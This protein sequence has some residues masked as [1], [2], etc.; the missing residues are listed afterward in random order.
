MSEQKKGIS[1]AS[2]NY[3]NSNQSY[4]NLP[5]PREWRESKGLRYEEDPNVE[6]NNQTTAF[7][8]NNKKMHI[9]IKNLTSE[10]EKQKTDRPNYQRET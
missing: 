4:N 7:L 5:S 2:K 1:I 3:Q 6:K 9:D 10:K 8:K